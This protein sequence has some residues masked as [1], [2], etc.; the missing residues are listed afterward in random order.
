MTAYT[1]TAAAPGVTY[2]LNKCM[3]GLYNGVGSGQVIRVYRVW[4]TNNQTVAVTGVLLLLQMS[5]ITTGSGGFA[6]IPTK[7]D[8]QAPTPPSQIVCASGLSYTI[9]TSYR[10]NVRSNDEPLASDNAALDEMFTIPSC[11]ILWDSY[12]DSTIQPITLREGYGLGVINTTSTAVG[13][14][15]F[16]IEFT[17]DS[18]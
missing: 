9:D 7:H 11:N 8:F 5:R 10:R 13:L 18:V 2:L 3:I 17:M 15:D 12:V 16:F 6:I 1:Y 4:S 14:A